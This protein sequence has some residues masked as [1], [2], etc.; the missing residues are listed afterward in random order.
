MRY[1]TLQIQSY[2]F[3]LTGLAFDVVGAFFLSIEAIKISNFQHLCRQILAG[4]QHGLK[5]PSII[6]KQEDGTISNFNDREIVVGNW[7]A[8]HPWLFFL[9]HLF[10]G[11]FLLWL[12]N[13]IS[14]GLLL[15]YSVLGVK[16]VATLNLWVAIPLGLWLVFFSVSTTAYWVGEIFHQAVLKILK[17]ATGWADFIE[18]NTATGALGIVGFITLAFGFSLQAIGTI[19]GTS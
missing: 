1:T 4:L 10:G 16:W 5:S 13:I 9:F 18:R 8:R 17:S 15:Q 19:Y 14:F 6:F 7:A 12:A 11:M 2:H 3:I